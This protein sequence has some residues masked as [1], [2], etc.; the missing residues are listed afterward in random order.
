MEIVSNSTNRS[1]RIVKP[2]E[3]D[4]KNTMSSS[5]SGIVRRAHDRQSF[6]I[7]TKGLTITIDINCIKLHKISFLSLFYLSGLIISS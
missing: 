5:M 7:V 4:V 6:D 2:D 1:F 3:W